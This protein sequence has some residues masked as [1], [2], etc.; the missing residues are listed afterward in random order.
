MKG[1]AYPETTVLVAEL[2]RTAI[3]NIRVLGGDSALI[4]SFRVAVFPKDAPVAAQ[5][6]RNAD[7]AL[8]GP[9]PTI[10]TAL[11]CSHRAASLYPVVRLA[12]TRVEDGVWATTQD[13]GAW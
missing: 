12:R 2:V 6:V 7:R 13:P 11:R 3:V 4:A 10:G 1:S 9:R 8:I 5:F